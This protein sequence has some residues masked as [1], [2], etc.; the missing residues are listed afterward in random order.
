AREQATSLTEINRA[1]NSIDQGTQ[2]NAAMVEESTAASHSLAGEAQSLFN[3]L[4]Q[5]RTGEAPAASATP[6]ASTRPQP[7]S[8]P[9]RQ[10]L[11]QVKGAFAGNAALATD[12]WEEF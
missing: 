5:F 9:A 8:S 4:T 1:V 11:R 2:Q 7:A 6:T 12:D 3:L 10:L